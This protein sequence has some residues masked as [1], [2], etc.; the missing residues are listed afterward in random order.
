VDRRFNRRRHD[1]AETITAFSARLR[2]QVA[3]DTLSSEL[4]AVVDQ[5]MQPTRSSLWLRPQAAASAT[6]Q[7][8][9]HFGYGGV[10]GAANS[11]RSSLTFTG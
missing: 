4:L 11:R 8:A 5:T 6:G 1:A 2:D 9:A 10:S 7:T 3:L